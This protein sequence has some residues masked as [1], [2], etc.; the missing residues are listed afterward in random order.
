MLVNKYITCTYKQNIKFT[1][2]VTLKNGGSIPSPPTITSKYDSQERLGHG[3]V[4]QL[5]RVRKIVF[6]EYLQI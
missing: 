1:Q 3:G 2:I 5:V 4:T 6:T